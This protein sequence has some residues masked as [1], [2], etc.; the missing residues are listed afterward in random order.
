MSNTSAPISRPAAG[1]ATG[2]DPAHSAYVLL[3][4][5]FIALPLLMG[6]DKF[7]NLF[8]DWPSYLAP[9]MT[10]ILPFSAQTAMYLIGIVEIV[11][12]V[13]MVIRPRWAA[14]VVALWLAGI[15]INL[16]TYSGF[17]DVA[18]RDFG[19]LIAAV[20]LGLLA[21]KYNAPRA[22]GLSA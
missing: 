5:G 19:L 8:T 12:A 22:K 20:A 2:K 11:A 6:L 21:Q 15:I 17:Y 1:I 10:D 14:W 9:W 16:L 7:T 13:A 3:R 18:L 4:L